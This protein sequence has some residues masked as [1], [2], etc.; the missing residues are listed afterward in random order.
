MASLLVTI[1][2]EKMKNE[3]KQ[4]ESSGLDLPAH[5][6]RYAVAWSLYQDELSDLASRALEREMD[7]AQNLFTWDEFQV[8][9]Q[10]LPGYIEFWKRFAASILLNAEQQVEKG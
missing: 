2:Y 7:A 4:S 1:V 10:T 8:F 3:A 9:K 6:L 5:H